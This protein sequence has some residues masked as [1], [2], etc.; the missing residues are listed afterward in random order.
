MGQ[1]REKRLYG[2]VRIGDGIQ[3]KKGKRIWRKGTREIKRQEGDHPF[4]FFSKRLIILKS[5]PGTE[6]WLSRRAL[7]WHVQGI[8]FNPQHCK[9]KKKE[10][11]PISHSIELL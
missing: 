10:K 2:P 11:H 1:G 8:G 7:A 9:K 5:S 4:S 6:V 3:E